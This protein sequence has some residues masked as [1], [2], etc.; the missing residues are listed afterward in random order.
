MKENTWRTRL[1]YRRKPNRGGLACGGWRSF[2]LDN[3]LREF[4]VCVFEPG[5]LDNE[6]VVLDVKIFHVK[7]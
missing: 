5:S 3:K 2:V 6:S 4:D 1:Y 7:K